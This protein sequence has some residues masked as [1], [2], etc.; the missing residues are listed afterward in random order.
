MSNPFK[1]G[2]LVLLAD[3]RSG[4]IVRLVGRSVKIGGGRGSIGTDSLIGR[5]SGDRI[6]I[7]SREFM[8][9]RPD[10]MDH[11]S[12]IERGPQIILPKDSSR[13]AFFLGIRSGDTVVEAGAGSG[14]LTLALLNSVWPDGKVITYDIREDHLMFARSNV[15]RTDM[16]LCWEG[17]IADVRSGIPDREVDAIAMDVPDPEKAV[18]AMEGSLK[19]GGRICCFVP[20]MNQV[21]RC[22]MA[23]REGHYSGIEAVELIERKL[24]VKEGAVRPDTDMLGHTGYIIIARL[25]S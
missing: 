2:E 24:S 11:L 9:L 25:S 16:S 1:E 5:S 23:L 4:S 21:E 17:R 20:T 15:A 18:S 3:G 12:S 13:I 19:P 7:G 22:I 8:L 6:A 10:V 14:G